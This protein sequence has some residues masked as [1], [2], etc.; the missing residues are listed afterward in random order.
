MKMK[1][2]QKI[3]AML[4]MGIVLEFL[5]LILGLLV[6]GLRDENWIRQIGDASQ[7]WLIGVI[8]RATL[9]QLIASPFLRIWLIEKGENLL[10]VTLSDFI[11]AVAWVL[12]L[13]AVLG[14]AEIVFKVPLFRVAIFLPILGASYG[15]SWWFRRKFLSK[16]Q[17]HLRCEG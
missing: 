14:P 17:P 2:W 8:Y 13:S 3:G 9:L 4:V 5:I 10:L 12:G 1:G 16:T 6:A 11:L 15:S 7:I